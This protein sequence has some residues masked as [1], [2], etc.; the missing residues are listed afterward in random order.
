MKLT[1]LFLARAYVK[2]NPEGEKT[3]SFKDKWQTQT[4]KLTETEII[5]HMKEPHAA[6]AILTGKINNITV[7]DF[8]TK[9]NPLLI[10]LLEVC[11]TYIV[12]TF[13][14]FHLYFKYTPEIITGANRFGV[15][16]DVRNDGG[17]IFC[18]PTP[19]YEPWGKEPIADL[20]DDAKE[21]LNKYYT[22]NGSQAKVSN[23]LQNTT[24]RNDSLFR[25]ACGWIEHYTEQE[26]W[27]R[28]VK[29]N[30]DFQKG[31]LEE[32]ELE[33]IYQQVLKYK[34]TGEISENEKNNLVTLTEISSDLLNEVRYPIGFS[35]I[36]AVLQE[37]ELIGK[38][39]GGLR[40]GEMLALTGKPGTGKTLLATQITT[41]MQKSGIKSLWFSYEVNLR[42]LKRIF[43]RQGAD[44]NM[45]LSIKLE[46]SVPML[47]NI[48]WIEKYVKQAINN[49][50]K[51]IVLDN[52]DFIELRQDKNPNYS[53]NQTAFL[54]T[55]V[56]Q[57][58]NLVRQHQIIM[59]LIAHIRKPATQGLRKKRPFLH[60]IA[61]TS[62]VER[63]CSVGMVIDR[64]ENEDG[65]YTGPS[66]IYLDKNRPGGRREVVELFYDKGTFTETKPIEYATIENVKEM[67]QI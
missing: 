3:V 21:V 39:K 66:K 61:G 16:V 29:A 4:I 46:D 43:E 56:T 57:L 47:G 35:T 41:Q 60:D 28:M 67:F 20:N 11:P 45:I 38:K 55:I 37:E 6:L 49:N 31:E 32:K 53:M 33:T 7:I 62:Q 36:D 15:G 30:R 63:L 58:Y 25:K 5:T 14:G 10:E 13:K 48:D 26:V 64:E 9:D 12:Q 51:L 34:K 65:I 24:S 19:H 23:D 50:V 18:P 17:L 42:A 44:M 54:G 52:L 8:D 2:R 59:I 27:S 1:N 22:P 40:E